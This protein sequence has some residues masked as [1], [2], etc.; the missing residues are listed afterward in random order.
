MLALVAAILPVFLPIVLGGWLGSRT[1]PGP[2]FWAPVGRLSD[3]VFLPAL[4]VTTLSS[5]DLTGLSVLPMLAAAI[6]AMLAMSALVAAGRRWLSVADGPG[7][8]GV[9]RGAIRV[10]AYV[11]LAIA[12][13]VWGSAGV[14]VAV[15]CVAAIVPAATAIGALA[16]VPRRSASRP[17]PLA[18]LTSATTDP[19]LLAALV[20]VVG[21]LT[22]VPTVVAEVLDV[23]GRAALPIG[24]LCAGAALDWSAARR[25]ARAAVQ[26]AA[27]KL[28]AMPALTALALWAFGVEG[29]TAAVALLVVAAPTAAASDGPARQLDGDTTLLAGAAT[30]QTAACAVSLP[31]ILTLAG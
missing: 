23:L 20:G 1:F 31:A 22:G 4:I 6:A 26:T 5:A 14:T 3:L 21:Q 30:L 8:A 11:G 27:L 18:I 28:L 2:G 17:A 15:I 29:L 13:A 19:L 9:L 7:F 10:N 25:H 16:P 24:L 12:S